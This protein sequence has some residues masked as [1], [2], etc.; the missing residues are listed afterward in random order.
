[1]N[2]RADGSRV[3]DD[4]GSVL[5]TQ[6]LGHTSYNALTVDLK[7]SLE[8][9]FAFI[10]HYLF[11]ATYT[12]SRSNDQGNQLL[13]FLSEV[14]YPGDLQLDRGPASF[15]ARHRFAFTGIFDL[16]KN[17]SV[18]PSIVMRSTLPFEIIQNHDFSEGVS[19][20]FYRLPVLSRNAG[21]RQIRSGVDMNRAID[22]F[23]ANPDLVLAHG[24]PISH[25]DPR[26]SLSRTFFSLDCQVTKKVQFG[27]H[28]SLEVGV[29]SFNLFNRTNVIGLSSANPSGLQNN[30]ESPSFG[31]PLGVTGGGFFT[32]GSPRAFQLT[33]RL[34]F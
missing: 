12:L 21:N 3:N 28:M 8:N 20:G 25:V 15:D 4:F 9:G 26:L 17:I 29:E 30:V 22:T 24:G 14:S 27:E 11:D 13:S 2:R 6:S 32:P 18:A 7:R 34:T 23:N 33:T 1:M 19:S 10:R 5:E 31:K 16:M